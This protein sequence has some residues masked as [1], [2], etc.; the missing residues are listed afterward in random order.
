MACP[1]GVPTCAPTAAPTAAP[2][3]EV[4]VEFFSLYIQK[5][6]IEI[7]LPRRAA[8]ERLLCR[9]QLLFIHIRVI[10][11]TPLSESSK[12]TFLFVYMVLFVSTSQHYRTQS[13]KEYALSAI[14]HALVDDYS[15]VFEYIVE[16]SIE[17]SLL[18]LIKCLS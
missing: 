1:R 13:F 17:P 2:F 12:H 8:H 6:L 9:Y 16:S 15:L 5:L 11:D 7:F 10:R 3:Q 4:P 14:S 18:L